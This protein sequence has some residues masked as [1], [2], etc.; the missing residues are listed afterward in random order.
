MATGAGALAGVAGDGAVRDDEDG[1]VPSSRCMAANA[2]SGCTARAA[3]G[4]HAS[5]EFPLASPSVAVQHP[6]PGPEPCWRQQA[7]AGPESRP[8]SAPPS[9]WCPAVTPPVPSRAGRQPQHLPSRDRCLAANCSMSRAYWDRDYWRGDAVQ[10]VT[11]LHHIE[12]RPDGHA[13]LHGRRCGDRGRPRRCRRTG[14][15]T[16]RAVNHRRRCAGGTGRAARRIALASS[17]RAGVRCITIPSIPV[18]I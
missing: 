13:R 10:S 8:P 5:A 6:P 3:F 4:D 2:A 7:A 9:P 18:Q 12:L 14:D 15:R 16:R 1:V 17:V 11:L